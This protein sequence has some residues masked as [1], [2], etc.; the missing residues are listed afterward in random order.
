MAHFGFPSDPAKA[1]GRRGP[2]HRNI[3]AYLYWSFVRK[4]A[5]RR[6]R[7]QRIQYLGSLEPLESLQIGGHDWASRMEDE[8]LFEQLTG[9][10][11]AKVRRMFVL[12]VLGYSWTEIGGR[13]GISAHNAEVRFGEDRHPCLSRGKR[14]P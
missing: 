2:G 7:E 11:D 3:E 6:N 13:F 4:H 8:I 1:G 9:Y 10:M 14:R 5:E 12:R